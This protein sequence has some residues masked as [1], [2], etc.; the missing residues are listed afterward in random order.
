MECDGFEVD[1]ARDTSAPSG[2][3]SGAVLATLILAGLALAF[4]VVDVALAEEVEGATEAAVAADPAAGRAD[5][6]PPASVQRWS[7][8]SDFS[9]G[10]Y[11][12]SLSRGSL[13][14][15]LG[16]DTPARVRSAVSP[17]DASGPFVQTLPT[18]SLGLRSVEVA[19]G[20]SWLRQLAGGDAASGLTHRVGIEWKPAE[21]QLMFVREGL[22]MRLG[23]DDRLTMRLRKGTLGIYMKRQF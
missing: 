8:A 16:F 2:R 19:P 21:S 22:G 3:R 18:V 11:K 14:L 23:G 12:W 7:T 4:A 17:L 13:D 5:P 1:L 20:G 10:N 6:D 15:G 9:A